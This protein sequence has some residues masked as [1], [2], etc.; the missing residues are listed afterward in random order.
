MVTGFGGGG[1]GKNHGIYMT[2][3]TSTSLTEP[4]FVGT[5]GDPG[6]PNSLDRAGTHSYF[7]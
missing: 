1:T 5:A 7:N 2:R 6:A 3:D 4:D